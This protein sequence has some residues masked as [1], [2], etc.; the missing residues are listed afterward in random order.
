MQQT[1]FF[2]QRSITLKSPHLNLNQANSNICS[3][4]D[5]YPQPCVAYAFHEVFHKNIQGDDTPRV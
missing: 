5:Q 4:R 2:D 1:H 3:I